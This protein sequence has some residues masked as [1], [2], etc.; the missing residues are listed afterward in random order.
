MKHFYEIVW[1]EKLGKT[2]EFPNFWYFKMSEDGDKNEHDYFIR[3]I[4]TY[5]C[6]N[7]GNNN[8]TSMVFGRR[9]TELRTILNTVRSSRI[10]SVLASR[11]QVI[12]HIPADHYS[13]TDWLSPSRP[14]SLPSLQSANQQSL[15]PRS[16]SILPPPKL[17]LT[18]PVRC[19]VPL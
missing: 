10:P 8:N 7:N 19:S 13:T 15:W 18:F 1:S 17:I 12:F 6:N 9:P 4:I 11:R 16:C 2:V 5:T 3:S 14:W